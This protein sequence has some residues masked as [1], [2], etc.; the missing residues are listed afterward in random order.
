MADVERSGSG[1]TAIVAI[2]AIAL[3]V[4]AGFFLLRGGLHRGGANR[5]STTTSSPGVRGNIEVN[6]PKPSGQ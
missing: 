2:F 1:S 4:M 6:T 3:L 5:G